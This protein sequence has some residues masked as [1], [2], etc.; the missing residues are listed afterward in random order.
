MNRLLVGALLATAGLVAGCTHVTPAAAASSTRKHVTVLYV[1]DLHAQ[2]RAFWEQELENVF[3]A[4]PARRFGGW[5]P[6]PSGLT[7]RFRAHAPRG[8]RLTALEVGGR[9][10]EDDR[11][12]TVAACE[13]E[14]DT[15]DML[16]RIPG[17]RDTRTLELD[18]HEAVRRHLARHPRLS[19][20]L[21]GRAVGED[22]PAVLRTQQLP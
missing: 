17:A 5:L 8:Q 7:L 16:C 4:D 19:A 2:L 21:Q 11:L 15:P 18:A 10:V 20:A 1:A 14:G 6:R 13:R 9:P 12:Y 22:L 3:A